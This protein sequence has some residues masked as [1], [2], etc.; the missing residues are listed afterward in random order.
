MDICISSRLRPV[1]ALQLLATSALGLYCAGAMAGGPP[2]IRPLLEAAPSVDFVY[3]KAPGM[4]VMTP[5][6]AGGA[7]LVTAGTKSSQLPEGGE[8]ERAFEIPN[9]SSEI[10]AQLVARL[11]SGSFASKLHVEDH[12]HERPWSTDPRAYH[13]ETQDPY[14]LELFVD[15]HGAAYMPF[16][17]KTYY[18]GISARL[19]LIDVAQAKVVWEHRCNQSGLRGSTYKLKVDEFEANSGARLK[20]VER[21]ANDFCAHEL[22]D[23]LGAG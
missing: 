18:Y 4:S 2:D 21:A 3:Y 1:P 20:E 14:V 7:N 15:G 23:L 5:A 8:L 9:A 12:P 11:K 19:R 22:G 17:W 13:G 16:N 6:M 10:A